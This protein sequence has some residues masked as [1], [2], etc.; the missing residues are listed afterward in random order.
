[1]TKMK[2]FFFIVHYELNGGGSLW[3]ERI[4]REWEEAQKIV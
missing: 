3:V 1:M 2:I 4:G